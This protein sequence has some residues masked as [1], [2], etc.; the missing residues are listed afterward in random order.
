VARS[1]EQISDAMTHQAAADDTY[2]FR[3]HLC[4]PQ[5]C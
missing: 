5:S 3:T 4:L 1:G 2:F